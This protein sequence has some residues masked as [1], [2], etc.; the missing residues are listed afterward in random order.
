MKMIFKFKKIFSI[1]LILCVLSPIFLFVAC[2]GDES[3]PHIYIALGDSVPS[4]YGLVSPTERYTYIFYEILRK[5]GYTEVD[6][7]INMA[8]EGYTTTMLLELL[9]GM[10]NEQL[11]LFKSARIVTLN[12]GGNNILTPFKDYLTNN[13]DIIFEKNEE[14]HIT[15]EEIKEK[16]IAAWNAFKD[17]VSSAIDT[18]RA[19]LG[20][21]TPELEIALENGVQTFEEEFSEIIKWIKTKA[22]KATI[23][24]NTIYNPI[25]ERIVII[26]VELSKKADELIQTMNNIIIEESKTRGFFVADVYSAFTNEPNM[27][28]VSQFNLNPFGG[29]LSI[30]IIHP[31]RAGHTIIAEL[32]YEQYAIARIEKTN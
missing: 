22:P 15:S 30:D 6:E 29:L 12:I 7:E 31:N 10:T 1:I 9:K 28:D 5:E 20:L 27:M 21:F 8:V 11:K 26:P 24:V 23:I 2:S 14:E 13:Q 4:G 3:E 32:I 25:P 19:L 18:G 16:A 17:G